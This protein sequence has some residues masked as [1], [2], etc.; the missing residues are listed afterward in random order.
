[1]KAYRQWLPANTYEAIAS[2]GGSFYSNNIEDYYLTPWD[3]GYGPS[4]KFDHDFV[5]REALARMAEGEHR[6]K[7]TLAL[8]DEDVTRTIGTMFQKSDRAKFMDWPSGVYAMHQYDRVSAEGGTVGVSTWI[9]Y[10][11]NEGKMLTLAVLDSGHAEPGTEVVL[12]WGEEDGGTVKPTV[13]RHVQTE[14]R[15][16][17][18]PVPY[19]EAVRTSY[20]PGGWRA[21]HP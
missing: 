5:G 3:L 14:I 7:V 11:A 18:C 4:V 8:D 2:L 17:V 16:V 6:R 21:A 1:M 9:G 13:E 12:L 20:A 10:S 15:A 19:V